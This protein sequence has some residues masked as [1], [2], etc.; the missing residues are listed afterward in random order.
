MKNDLLQTLIP[1]SL[2]PHLLRTI[3]N[4]LDWEYNCLNFSAILPERYLWNL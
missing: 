4:P 1:L 3:V 2:T